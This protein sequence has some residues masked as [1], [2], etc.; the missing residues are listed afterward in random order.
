MTEQDQIKFLLEQETDGKV[1][2]TLEGAS[3]AVY[4]IDKGKDHSP[5]KTA[6]KSVQVNKMTDEKMEYFVQEC[7]LWLQIQSDYIATAFYPQ[8]IGNYLF[9]VMPFFDCS[10]Q[11][12]LKD[13]VEGKKNIG[14]LD[15][16]VIVCKITKALIE[17]K[18]CGINY[19]QDFNPPNILIELLDSKFK[20][21][22]TNNYVNYHIVIADFGMAKLRDRIGPIKG[23]GGGKFF[24]I[25]PEQYV[26]DF[27]EDYNPD[28][29]ALGVMIY[30]IF[31]GKHPSGLENAVFF[32]MEEDAKTCEQKE[33]EMKKKS[34]KWASSKNKKIEP[35]ENTDLQ[36]YIN[37][38][39]KKDPAE[40]PNLDD[41]HAFLLKEL[42]KEDEGVHYQLTG[43]FGAR[44]A[45]GHTEDRIGRLYKLS[46]VAQLPNKVDEVFDKL[47]KEFN[48]LK[49]NF[50][51]AKD[52][53]YYSTM[54]GYLI[55]ISKGKHTEL[56]KKECLEHI[57][58]V[59]K[60]H[61]KIKT[62]DLEQYKD[63]EYQGLVLQQYSRLIKNDY[64]AVIECIDCSIDYLSNLEPEEVLETF[65]QEFND[66]LFLSYFYY[67]RALNSNTFIHDIYKTLH[68][69][70]KAK[71]KHPTELFFYKNEE[72][73]IESFLIFRDL[74]NELSESQITE[75]SDRKNAAFEHYTVMNKYVNE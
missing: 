62:S 12:L 30:M 41:F 31:T 9:I 33:Q 65:F 42:K 48:I 39:L 50:T 2:A 57:K 8:I 60:W 45:Y 47:Y 26:R 6:Y 7:E 37:G 27:Y 22:P 72:E 70:S 43:F 11:S 40:R 23:G 4:V 14:Y 73:W 59:S 25:A 52:V 29:F 18:K 19:H 17:L 74:Y 21:F 67:D 15:G 75:L 24:Y 56:L 46:R 55:S 61:K 53:A 49:S 1:I 28:I 32:K 64:L 38:M 13:A 16:L 5:R 51:N 10:L 63:I 44:D 71:E 69:L 20:D 66:D 58:I 3:G 35:L 36:N 34:R 54:L 68:F